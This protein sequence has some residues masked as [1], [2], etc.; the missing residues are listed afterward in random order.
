MAELSKTWRVGLILMVC[1]TLIACGGQKG[2]VRTVK[3]NLPDVAPIL[4]GTI[5][6]ETKIRRALPTIL[7]GYGLVVGLDGTGGTSVPERVAATMER[8]LAIRGVGRQGMFEGTLLEGRSPQDVLRDPDVAVVV[9]EAAV[10]LA[11]PEGMTFDV[12][13][14]A[15]AGSTTRSLE[16]GRLWTTKMQAGPPA[17]VGGPQ[18]REVAEASGDL[19]INPFADADGEGT[20]DANPRVGRILGGGRMTKPLS[21]EILMANPLHARARAIARAVNQRFPNGPKGPGTT[22]RGVS[23]AVVEVSV[24]IEFRDRFYEFIEL[25][26]HLPINPDFPEENARR[27]VR[28]LQQGSELTTELSWALRALGE[29]AI[30]FVRDLYE[31]PRVEVRMAA[32]RA[33]ANLNDPRAGLFLREMAAEPGPER[34][35]AISLLGAVDGRP[36]I[37]ETL[38]RIIST[39]SRLELRVA[40]YESLARRAVRARLKTLLQ[41]RERGGAE[42]SE[43]ELSRIAERSIPAGMVQGITR[44]P[45]SERFVVDVVPFGEP[46]VYVTQQGNPTIVIFGE[47]PSVER[48]AYLSVW[49][50]DLLVVAEPDSEDVRVRFRDEQTGWVVQESVD[51]SLVDIV[52]F[53]AREQT[54]EQPEPGLRMT[55]S[56]L[57]GALFAIHEADGTAAGFATEGDRLLASLLSAAAADVERAREDASAADRAALAEESGQ[58]NLDAFDASRERRP[59]GRSRYIVPINRGSD[60]E[61]RGG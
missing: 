14:R 60:G 1:A 6:S 8:E 36:N 48:P 3:P 61:R 7:S 46:L 23:D 28:A 45:L 25:V 41:W 13:V 42:A 30:P 57:V 22:A 18:T 11:S 44:I 20:G 2:R 5:G 50:G 12:R 15:L 54:P 9:V 27:Y 52:R 53:F 33:G 38:R 49:G 56:D 35:E 34:S 51:E 59:S 37:D 24:P 19:Y 55:Y 29:P 10:P 17:V 32:L 4:R 43:R 26:R 21:L 40:A 39:E 58:R 31:D 47:D 16:G